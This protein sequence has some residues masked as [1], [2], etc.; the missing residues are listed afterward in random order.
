ML[1]PSKAGNINNGRRSIRPI[2]TAVTTITNEPGCPQSPALCVG[3]GGV[4]MTLGDGAPPK[5]W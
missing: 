5:K 1:W 2:V 4:C 3:M